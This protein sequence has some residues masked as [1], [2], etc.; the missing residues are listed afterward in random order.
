MSSATPTSEPGAGEIGRDASLPSERDWVRRARHRLRSRWSESPALYLP[1]ARRRH[2]GPSPEVIGP[3]T[4]LVIDG[5][6]RSATTFAVYAFQLAQVSP[7]RLAHHLHAPAQLIEAAKRGVPAIALI[8]DPEGAVL[9]QVL[10]EPGVAVA[11][12]LASYTRFYSC[13]MPHRHDLVVGEFERVTDAFDA[14]V[15]AVNDRYATS[16]A[17]PG[18]T[19]E[20][21][22]VTLDLVAQRATSN[23]EWFHALLSFE[24]GLIDHDGLSAVRERTA[25]AVPERSLETWGPSESRRALKA[26]LRSRWDEPRLEGSRSRAY[27]AYRSFVTG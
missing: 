15:R 8:R 2:P 24:S 4:R 7:V 17:I 11:D 12:A 10:R 6:T 19:Q 3:D 26:R 14:V 25:Q 1:A 5:Y 22:D 27:D 16:F 21:R 13:L 9:S 18:S 20:D 23:P